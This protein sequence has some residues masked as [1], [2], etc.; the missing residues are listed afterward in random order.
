MHGAALTG[1]LLVALGAMAGAYCLVRMRASD[2]EE[3]R[4]AGGEAAMGFGMAVMALPAA[5]L[6]PPEWTWVVYAAVFGATALLGLAGAARSGR[7][8]LHHLHH[9][10]DSLAM[11]YMAVAMAAPALLGAR[12]AHGGHGAHA[13]FSP[14]GASG[15][16]GA[17]G[18][19]GGIPLLTGALLLYY[20]VYVLHAGARLVPVARPVPAAVPAGTD[21]GVGAGV[22]WATRPELT[23]ACRLSMALAMVAMLFTL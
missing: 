2:G 11:L 10:V 23:L 22:S 13:G 15:T 7:R 20:V 18:G 16:A 1:W 14:S 4:T 17:I 12:G 5:V 8:R 6:S 19:V 3:R 21:S 9:L